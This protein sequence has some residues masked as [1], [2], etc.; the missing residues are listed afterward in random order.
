MRLDLSSKL[1]LVLLLWLCAFLLDWSI[2]L[3]L[4]T[5]LILVRYLLPGYRPQSARA[6]KS[7]NKFL[8][9]GGTIVFLFAGINA[10]FLRGG[11]VV[12]TIATLDFHEE[13]LMFGIRTAVRLLLLSI[14][15]LLFFASTPLRDFI[16]FLQQ[17]GLPPQLVLVLLLTLHF[18]DQLPARIHQVFVAQE[19]RG[20]PVRAGIFSRSQA[21]FSVVSPLVLSSIIESIDR[22]TALEVR[23]FLHKPVPMPAAAH[24][25]RSRNLLTAAVIL[26][27]VA[28]IIYSVL[29]WLLV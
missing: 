13:G 4:I 26:L 25:Q 19:A 1:A 11:D 23:G 5:L 17:K 6:S 2:N 9:Y 12:L 7:F 3:I 21:L 28:I 8:F 15:I 10:L 27:S 29:R 24:E 20:A 16:R 18:L 22:G 14:S